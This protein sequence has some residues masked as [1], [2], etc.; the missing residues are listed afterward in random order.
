M[1]NKT[2]LFPFFIVVTVYLIAMFFELHYVK[3][4]FKPLIVGS[5]LLYFLIVT[6]NRF[7]KFKLWMLLA[8]IY[9]LAGDIFL[10]LDGR[11][12]LFFILGL[13]SFLVGHIFYIL[14][15]RRVSRER[16]V[17]FN[18]IKTLLV[19]AYVGTLLY[20]LI[21]R[22]GVLWLPVVLYA[23]VIGT[24]LVFALHLTKIGKIGRLIATGAF[25]FVISDSVIA[26]NKFYTPV[27]Y[28]HWI[29]MITYI[30][31][32]FLIIHGVAKYILQR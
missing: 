18:V 26:L 23:L 32:Q 11:D 22:A 2:P 31:A 27:P 21:P 25:L 4:I 7:V 6:K 1:K 16:F 13:A 24:M 12:E 10:M 8:M 20:L 19:V 9:C 29:V 28:D 15:F 5:L 14:V 3:L 17:S 30:A